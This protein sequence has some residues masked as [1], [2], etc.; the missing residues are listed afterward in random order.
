M[1]IK[2]PT[3]KELEQ[4][5]IKLRKMQDNTIHA[6]DTDNF[7]HNC[8]SKINNAISTA[9]DIEEMMSNA[10]QVIL[11][12][13]NVE[14]A[15]LLF[16]CDPNAKSWTVPMERTKPGFEG[17]YAL[18]EEI[19][20]LPK[21]AGAFSKLQ[22]SNEV[23][24]YDYTKSPKETSE[25]FSV[26]SEMHM[27]L[28]PKTGKAWLFGV[29]QCINARVWTNEEKLV[30]KEIGN[31]LSDALNSFLYLS[32]LRAREKKFKSISEI[33]PLAI[34]VSSGIQ[35]KTDYVNP[36]FVQ[37]FG[38]SK[39]EIQ[40]VSNWWPLAYPNE[41]Y[42]KKISLEW[43][44]KV[45]QAIITKSEIEPMETVVTCKD[46]SEK[47]IIWGFVST[48]SQNWSFGLDMTKQKQAEESL[49]ASKDA[50]DNLTNSLTD[51]V[52]SV[53]M[54]ER[55][56]EWSNNSIKSIDYKPAEI[57][58]ETT[59]F[60]FTDEKYYLDF[61]SKLQQS[62]DAGNDVFITEQVFKKKN[63]EL[64]SADVR[65]T[66]DKEEGK[67]IRATSIIRD[68]TEQK[69]AQGKLKM[70]SQVIDHSLNAFDIVN[71]KGEFIYVNQAYADMW[72][73]ET[74]DEIIGT[75]PVSHCVDE[76][77]AG[78]I[79]S[80]I[81]KNGKFISEI[82]AKR[83]DNS[84]FDVLMYARLD[85]DEYGNEIYPT[86]SLDITE[87][88]QA[89][90]ELFIAKEKWRTL[91]ENS[92]NHIMLL[93]TNYKIQ[94]VNY[95][96]PD[97]T[98]DQVIGKSVLDFVPVDDSQIAVDCFDRVRHSGNS[99]RY[100]T[101]YIVTNGELQ[102]F[103]VLISP[104]KDEEGS[105]TGFISTSNNV[106][107]RKQ[108]E[109]A[110]IESEER[111]RLALETN[112][113]GAWELNLNDHTFKRTL[114]HDHIFGYETALS[115]WTFK[116]FL[117]HVV[118]KDRK[119][120]E[121]LFV[122]AVKTKSDWDFECRIQRPDGEIRWISAIGRHIVNK[123]GK[124]SHLSGVVQ[125]ITEQKKAQQKLLQ[126][127]E[128]LQFATEGANIGTWHW[129]IITG[130]LIWSPIM[131]KL[132]DIPLEEVITYKRFS[133]ALH[134]D[135]RKI[136]DEAV[137]AALDNHTD[138]SMEYRAIWRDGSVHW[139]Y[140]LGRG[141][142]D[143]SGNNIR[144]EGVVI[145]INDKKNTELQLKKKNSEIESQNKRYQV[146]NEQF[147]RI[148]QLLEESQSIAKLGGWELNLLTNELYWTAE[149]YRIHDTS[150]EEFD[151]TVDAG[152][153]YFLP[154]SKQLIIE[155]LEAATKE[156][157]GYDLQ[158]ETYTT[159]GRKIDVRTTGVVSKV[160]GKPIKITGIFQDISD[161]KNA[162]KALIE[163]EQR[164]NEAQ[165]MASI[166]YWIQD[167]PSGKLIWSDEAYRIF[168]VDKEFSG[169][170]FD[171]FI[172]SI[173][174][175]DR[176]I[177]ANAYNNSLETKKPYEITH[178]LQMPDGR[179]KYVHERCK[180][181]YDERGNPLKSIGTVQDITKLQQAEEELI[182]SKEKLNL[183]LQ[184]GGIGVWEWDLLSNR[185][186]WDSK[187]EHMFGLEEGEFNQTYD[188]FKD[189]LHP[190]DIASAENAIKKAIDGVSPYDIVYRVIWK[191][192]EVKYIR[193]KALLI[194]DN[195]GRP[196]TMIGICIDISTI[197]KTEEEIK[198][199][200]ENLEELVIKRT[201]ELEDK[202]NLL[203]RINKAFV[204]R[205]L[206][207]KE[208]KEKIKSLNKG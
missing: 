80:E 51:I 37:L 189:C 70:F 108:A 193:A 144:M 76:N 34:I 183:A 97:L 25:R 197:K 171:V 196:I 44:R 160:N 12:L 111:L 2:K 137:K 182:R 134:P 130:E 99:D 63:G 124:I 117:E 186:I 190:D 62:V 59:A 5:V 61:G 92:P 119:K 94:F 133:Q 83:K 43:E 58:G 56:I 115:E 68:I 33:S 98:V 72:G 21:D 185:T 88:K 110:L 198:K 136:T 131:N 81:K 113:T 127:T 89:E 86:T 53:R 96:V 40:S 109:K 85:Y 169:E 121:A 208:L 206:K 157:I 66:C 125:D 35:Q 10:L 60:L 172:A 152:V 132:F 52:I 191:N 18:G 205:E 139:L 177:V 148:N 38:Y 155:A 101:K 112:N 79:I 64:F 20:M 75:S 161:Q 36:T 164:L 107:E 9:T 129:N 29:H 151:P 167:V 192:K 156:G 27:T 170:L 48:D 207:M 46:G 47:N 42:R 128:R 104:V 118:P 120:T 78:H 142:Y 123:E 203:E 162:Q 180:T 158:L 153:G 163:S 73:Y 154:E 102:Y 140:A 187:M 126:I 6:N 184:G 49:R 24:T 28:H 30:F 116:M 159:K 54:P 181:E 135:D 95:T 23:F 173:H 194:K 57:I 141:Y 114:I 22:N 32:E 7:H 100:E 178:K 145:D 199:H 8:I 77:L 143:E 14:R 13:F 41:E 84:V 55:V 179:V 175:E 65:V 176:D 74:I 201:K 1:K 195:E 166:G 202:N 69:K 82:K 31:R 91:T 39:E 93:D 45:E 90:Q 168:E 150:P 200:K 67:V 3:Y 11:D 87:R 204:G 71:H 19:S 103:D 106:T 4:E 174:P 147:K 26:L 50:I 105:I 188:A 16:P 15:W 146:V 165:R 149:T 17:V 138:F 122:E